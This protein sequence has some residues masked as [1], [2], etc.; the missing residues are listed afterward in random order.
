MPE[1][2]A[3]CDVLVCGAGD[4]ADIFDIQ[5]EEKGKDGFVAVNGE[6]ISRADERRRN[7]RRCRHAI[8]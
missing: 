1:L 4:A 5:T 2:V 6:E 3:E 7:R 8:G